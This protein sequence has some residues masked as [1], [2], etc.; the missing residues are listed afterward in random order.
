MNFALAT[1]E[2][3]PQLRALLRSQPVPGWV[4][5]CYEREPDF[6]HAAA[7][8][9]GNQTMLAWQDGEIVGLGCRSWRELY[10]NGRAAKIGYLSGLRLREPVRNRT[11]LARGYSF[12]KQLHNAAKLPGYLSTVIESNTHAI[13]LLT[14]R[15]A[16]LPQYHDLGRFITF[17]LPIGG[18]RTA[19]GRSNE[20]RIETA[21]REDFPEI[22]AFLNDQGSRRQFFPVLH[23]S[24]FAGH[25]LWRGLGPEDFLVARK[26]DRSIA[27]VLGCW[28]QSGFKQIRIA[29]Y[30]PVIGCTRR[31]CNAGLRL[32]GWPQL[33]GPGQAL[34]LL[35]LALI[36]IRDDGAET[37]A[38]LLEAAGEK[39]RA[40]GFDYV[41]CGFHERNPLLATMK[42]FA[43][44]RY[45][46]RLFWV[47]WDDGEDFIR[48][49][50]TGRVPHLEVATL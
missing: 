3:E 17:V 11:A 32:I 22:I 48:S 33:P 27:G 4:R 42:G 25:F 36:T 13:R 15:R 18:K 45:T 6:F 8:Q 20:I 49:L 7:T 26:A 31:L 23:E 28:N 12:L 21:T 43:A 44:L 16:G 30:T 40:G 39:Q 37:F 10:F 35:N 46:S 19:N 9:G 29:G 50:D 47:C 41:C 5:L 14:S 38:A 1:S 34:K 24:D 2:D